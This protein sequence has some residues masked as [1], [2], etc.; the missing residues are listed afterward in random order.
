MNKY[1]IAFDGY[2]E[3]EAKNKDEAVDLFFEWTDKNFSYPNENF[4]LQ[5]YEDDIII[6]K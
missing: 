2:I 6:K 1:L 3:F 4:C 5:V